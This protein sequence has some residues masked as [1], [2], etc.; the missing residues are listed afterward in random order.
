MRHRTCS[1]RRRQILEEHLGIIE[2]TGS[3]A[4][5]GPSVQGWEAGTQMRKWEPL[6]VFVWSREIISAELWG[7]SRKNWRGGTMCKGAHIC[8][9]CQTGDICLS[10]ISFYRHNSI[11]SLLGFS[12]YLRRVKLRH[13]WLSNLTSS[14]SLYP[15]P[16]KYCIID[17]KEQ[18]D[19]RSQYWIS[20]ASWSLPSTD[21][22][23]L[24]QQE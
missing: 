2:F 19:G 16:N 8:W 4:Y 5:W 1:R 3:E 13:S 18:M 22:R 15:Y 11:N 10:M 20:S 9:M 17:K 7:Q 21:W 6:E 23:F 24:N 12:F 14:S